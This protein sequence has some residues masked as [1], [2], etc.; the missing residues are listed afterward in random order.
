MVG[1]GG[2]R[3]GLAQIEQATE[4]ITTL[5]LSRPKTVDR[6]LLHDG[7]GISLVQVES[8]ARTHMHR[9]LTFSISPLLCDGLNIGWC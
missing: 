3:W 1:V 9:K 8:T 4:H 5:F 6:W 2:A 7:N